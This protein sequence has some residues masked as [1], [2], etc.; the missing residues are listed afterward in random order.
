MSRLIL[1]LRHAQQSARAPEV[2][3]CLWGYG[4]TFDGAGDYA[5]LASPSAG[6]YADQGEFTIAFFFTRSDCFVPGTWETLF[7]HQGIGQPVNDLYL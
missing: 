3:S 4:L 1:R 7:A 2:D 5:I 6:N